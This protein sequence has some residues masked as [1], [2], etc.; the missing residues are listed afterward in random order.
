MPDVFAT[1]NSYGRV[2]VFLRRQL[3]FSG[4]VLVRVKVLVIV[5]PSKALSKR[6]VS[7]ETVTEGL[8]PRHWMGKHTGLGLSLI[9]RMT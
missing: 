8:A 7:W 4:Q 9:S 5:L 6:T 2:S 3:T 1:V